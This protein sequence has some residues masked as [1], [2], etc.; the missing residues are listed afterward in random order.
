MQT[1]HMN[2]E[3]L[4]KRFHTD[5]KSAQGVIA[6]ATVLTVIYII[7]WVFTKEF[8]F[9]FCTSFSEFLLKAARFSPEYR[10]NLPNAVAIA[11]AAGYIIIYFVA[12]ILA[13]KN[14][15]TL[16]F[17]LA[18]YVFDT[19]FLLAI[20]ITGY[21]GKFTG[22]YLIDI[23]FHVFILLFLIVGI[24]ACKRLEKMGLSPKDECEI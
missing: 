4:E 5:I 6:M 2:N 1:K 13:Q 12:V 18:L 11:A 19:V 17:S 8:D 3:Q 10:G 15:K 20:D 22:E 21:F 9:F 16:W 23:V 24:Y 7:R 14:P